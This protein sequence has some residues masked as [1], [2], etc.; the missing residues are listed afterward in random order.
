MTTAPRHTDGG[1]AAQLGSYWS[2]VRPSGPMQ[3]Q[4]DGAL[5]PAWGN[6]AAEVATIRV[7]AGTTIYVGSAAS[8]PI[9][10]GSLMG[11][12]SQVYIPSVSPAWLVP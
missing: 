10:G 5:N 3:A 7:P 12:G 11:G 9:L 1:E 2:K 8:Q 4:I 6:T